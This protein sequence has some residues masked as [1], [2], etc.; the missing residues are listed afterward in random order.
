VVENY[1]VLYHMAAKGSWPSIRV[2]GLLS[3]TALLDLHGIKGAQR[4]AVEECHRPNTI[5]ISSEAYGVAEIR[6][7]KPMSDAGLVRALQDGLTPKEWYRILNSKVF[8]WVS[9]VRLERLLCARAY[10]DLEHDVLFVSTKT[11]L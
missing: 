1:P 10:R 6:D 11:V 9:R 3:T 8:F 4:A 7:Q 2:H 5:T